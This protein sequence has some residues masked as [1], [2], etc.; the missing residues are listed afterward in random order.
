[1]VGSLAIRSRLSSSTGSQYLRGR[2]GQV[3]GTLPAE[4]RRGQ[5]GAQA[6][7][8]HQ[9][10]VPAARRGRPGRCPTQERQGWQALTRC[11]SAPPLRPAPCPQR[12]TAQARSLGLVHALAVR[13]GELGVHLAGTSR[14]YGAAAWAAASAGTERRR[15][16]PPCRPTAG[17]V[18]LPPAGASGAHAPQPCAHL[19]R[20]DGLAELGH[21]VRVGVQLPHHL[22]CGGWEGHRGHRLMLR[23][24]RSWGGCWGAARASSASHH[25]R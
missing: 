2:A 18:L 16:Q 22:R 17:H 1:M 15:W 25:L 12:A 21:G 19:E 6:V 4:G 13:L 24:R 3:G 14:G 8:R 9:F 5:A 23:G 11:G 7:P 10:P 20:Q